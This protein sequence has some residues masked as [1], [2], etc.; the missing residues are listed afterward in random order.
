MAPRPRRPVARRTTAIVVAFVCAVALAAVA[1]IG[2]EQASADAAPNTSSRLT[3]RGDRIVDAQG[4]TV[5]LHGVNNVDKD[6]PYIRPG[7]GF[8]LTER[9]AADLARH[10]FNAVRLGV[11]FDGLMPQRG[12]VDHDYIRR[13]VGVVDTLAA[14]G[15]HTL[16][17]NHQDGLSAP[18][19]GNGFPAWSLKSRPLP[20]EPNPGFPLY[21]LMP[22][23]NAA[24]DEV[25][26]NRHGVLD[27]LGTALGELTA[28]LKG[29]AGLLGVELLNEPWPGTAALTCFPVGCPLFDMRYQRAMEKLTRYVHR[30]D[31]STTVYWE[32]NV[33]WNQ[34]MPSY[35]GLT[36]IKARN[37]VIAPH[38][39]CIPSQLAIYLGLPKQLTAL[40]GP[41]QDLTWHHVDTVARRTHKPIVIT[42]FGDNDASVLHNTLTRADKRFVGW[43]YWHYTSRYGDGPAKADP[44]TGQVG[45]ELVRTYPQAVAGR[46]TRMSFETK[47]GA[48]SLT[49]TPD[50]AVT[51]PTVVYVS[52]RHYPEGA[53]VKVSGGTH[54]RDEDGRVLV[55][56]AGTGPVTVTITAR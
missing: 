32:P 25:W 43:M 10:G 16:L 4:R 35:L 47:T 26:T 27:Y 46:P 14:H 50:P 33:T 5:L 15:I 20:G 37:V 6:A 55:T 38:D 49:Y 44:M 30:A 22:S 34:M 23:M 53:S 40:C 51:A 42:E 8:T 41:Q 13:V 54:R 39:Y 48:F 11:S 36:G 17:D 9:D 24:W 3:V 29:H 18:W 31:P 2:V 1:P 12:A 21:Y 7:D 56:A 28:A 45:R 19:K 52:D